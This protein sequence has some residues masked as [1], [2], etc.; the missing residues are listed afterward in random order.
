M[1]RQGEECVKHPRKH[2]LL[3]SH[4]YEKTEAMVE[5][6]WRSQLVGWL[7]YIWD[8]DRGSGQ[9]VFK[10]VVVGLKDLSW[11]CVGER[12]LLKRLKPDE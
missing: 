12:E 2:E 5:S 9:G 3:F 8:L 10:A 1:W 11:D 7:L 4:K 6:F